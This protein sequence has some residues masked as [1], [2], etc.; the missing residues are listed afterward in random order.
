MTTLIIISFIV[1]LNGQGSQGAS[2]AITTVPFL[3]MN[4]CTAAKNALA[5]TANM[6]APNSPGS[7]RIV[8]YCAAGTA[9][10]VA[11]NEANPTELLE[12]I[13]RPLLSALFGPLL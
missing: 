10:P 4:G 7:Y 1:A 3:D 11:L 5:T 2:T 9:S 6:P 8:A 12:T 13:I